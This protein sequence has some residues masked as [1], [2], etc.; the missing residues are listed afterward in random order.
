MRSAWYITVS[1]HMATT[2]AGGCG[3]SSPPNGQPLDFDTSHEAQ[4]DAASIT[5]ASIQ[6]FAQRID[7]ESIAD[8]IM[9]LEDTADIRPERRFASRAGRSS[10]PR[11]SPARGSR[12]ARQERLLAPAASSWD[13]WPLPAADHRQA[14]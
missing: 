14:A 7:W 3:F 8:M 5:A 12:F 9:D 4:P 13:N 6:A 11:E 10:P 2:L 1:D